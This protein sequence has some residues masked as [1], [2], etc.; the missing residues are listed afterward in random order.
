MR[1]KRPQVAYERF[2][3]PSDVA[4]L[5][6]GLLPLSMDDK[7]IG[8]LQEGCLDFYRSWTGF[9]V[10]R[11]PLVPA[12]AGVLARGIIVNRGPRDIE[13]WPLGDDVEVVDWLV[14]WM[15]TGNPWQR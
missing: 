8:L 3:S 9:H 10:F 6:Y 12:E 11:L 7:W 14:N 15:L 4:D 1:R 5:R 13:N 2:F